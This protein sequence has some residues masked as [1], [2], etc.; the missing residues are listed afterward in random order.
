MQI[1]E[2]RKMKY[3]IFLKFRNNRQQNN[4]FANLCEHSKDRYFTVKGFQI[5][6]ILELSRTWEFRLFGRCENT[7]NDKIAC[8]TGRF[9][10]CEIF[11]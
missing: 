2:I 3:V 6:K 5:K 11:V 4:V 7:E 1:L 10:V 9:T 8:S